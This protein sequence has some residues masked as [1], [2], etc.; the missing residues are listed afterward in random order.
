MFLGMAGIL[1]AWLSI[2]ADEVVQD[3][4][5]AH[6]I[7][8]EGARQRLR[9]QHSNHKRFRNQGDIRCSRSESSYRVGTIQLYSGRAYSRRN[10]IRLGASRFPALVMTLISA[11]G[12]RLLPGL[13]WTT[14]AA[15]TYR[16][17]LDI[18]PTSILRNEASDE[19]AS[20][21]ALNP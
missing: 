4:F 21:A 15:M 14:P 12:D 11:Q 7:Y 16:F 8:A 5:V 2:V 17:A 6:A 1:G 3:A 18:W 13:S 10:P 20:S 19:D 9:R